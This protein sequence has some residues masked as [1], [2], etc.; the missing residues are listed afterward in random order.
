MRRVKRMVHYLH[1]CH[2]V[3]NLV[4]SETKL[5]E[6]VVPTNALEYLQLATNQPVAALENA[7]HEKGE[8][9]CSYEYIERAQVFKQNAL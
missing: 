8:K 7:L 1:L 6:A 3:L 5:V 2:F 9:Q 4:W